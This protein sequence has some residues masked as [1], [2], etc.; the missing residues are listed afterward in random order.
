MI[1][2][3]WAN[4]G[5]FLFLCKAAATFIQFTLLHKLLHNVIQNT[6]NKKAALG[7]STP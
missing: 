4:V 6:I 5:I 2:F 7:S 3:E 1:E